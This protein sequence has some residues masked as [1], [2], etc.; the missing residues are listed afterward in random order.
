MI[1]IFILLIFLL[2]SIF[3]VLGVLS[4]VNRN[5]SRWIYYLL[6]IICLLG[7]VILLF[8]GNWKTTSLRNG[9]KV[10]LPTTEKPAAP[11]QDNGTNSGNEIPPENEQPPV[12]EP[13]EE[14]PSNPA[15]TPSEKIIVPENE[16][17]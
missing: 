13:A 6:S 4:H 7:A 3:L 9:V 5:R 2:F 17:I 1:E 10:D 16:T 8:C 11:R 12:E 15:P 14:E